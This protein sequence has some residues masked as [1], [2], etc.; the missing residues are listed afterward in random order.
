MS[1]RSDIDYLFDILESIQRCLSY[2]TGLDWDSFVID[3]RTQDAVVRNLEIIGEAVKALSSQLRDTYP[4]IPWKD[5]DGA[6]DRL[7]HHYF[8]INNEIIWEIVQVDL[9]ELLPQI[10]KILRALDK[11][12]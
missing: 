4:E 6:R 7:I 12:N 1:E 9:P 2:T 11:K 5:V 8:G 10:Q 3:F